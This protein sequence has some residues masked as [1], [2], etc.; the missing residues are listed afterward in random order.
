MQNTYE[1]RGYEKGVTVIV[2]GF[3]FSATNVQEPRR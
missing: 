3:E 2:N 1:L